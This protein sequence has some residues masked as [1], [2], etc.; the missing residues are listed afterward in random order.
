MSSHPENP[1][2]FGKSKFI[3]NL[4]LDGKNNNEVREYYTSSG[5]ESKLGKLKNELIHNVRADLKHRGML[6]E[7]GFPPKKETPTLPS[8]PQP[9]PKEPPPSPTPHVEAT[10]EEKE[11]VEKTPK[12]APPSEPHEFRL[13]PDWDMLT[14]EMIDHVVDPE[15]RAR[16][17]NYKTDVAKLRE[18]I[19]PE[20]AT[21]GEIDL[22]RNDV[23]TKVGGLEE[24][25]NTLISKLD[26]PPKKTPQKRPPPKKPDPEGEDEEEVEEESDPEEAEAA[27]VFKRVPKLVETV[28]AL[29]AE[30]QESQE[31]DDDLLE[32]EGVVVIRKHIGFTAK[33]VMWY[34]IDR[35]SGFQGNLADYVNSC[36]SDAHKGRNIELAVTEKRMIK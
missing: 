8:E 33:S 35:S 10:P 1:Y 11:E 30:Q 7:Y 18:K 26:A 3:A 19:K 25:I 34:E 17:L 20:Y 28:N 12:P 5:L 9:I 6:D 27:E 2:A 21:R 4:I 14:P 32:V 16:I 15:L 31:G 24:K 13:R 36:I 29:E 22:L 23:S